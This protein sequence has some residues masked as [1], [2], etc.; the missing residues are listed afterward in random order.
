MSQRYKPLAKALIAVVVAIGLVLAARNAFSQWA[1]Q[2]RSA[3]DRVAQIDR[4]LQAATS[5]VQR[6]NLRSQRR[7]ALSAV[8]RLA[9]LNWSRIAAAGCCYALGLIPG[10]LVLCESTRVLGYRVSAGKAIAAQLV[11]HVGKYVPGKAMVVVIRAGRL[12][13]LGVPLV[14]GS[15]AVFLETLLMMAVGAAVAGCLVFWLPVPRWVAWVAL[16]GGIAATVPTLPPWIKWIVAKINAKSVASSLSAAP[17]QEREAVAAAMS[18]ATSPSTGQGWRF[19]VSAWCWQ[20]LAWLLIGASFALLVDSIPGRPTEMPAGTVFA[21]SV[22]S[23]ALAMVAGFASL[24]PGGAGVRELTLAMV[25]A[26]VI[27][28]SHALLA[29]ILARLLFIVVDLAAALAVAT[30]YREQ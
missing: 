14:V 15:I 6:E 18:P 9:N 25:L 24:L 12:S 5:E 26:P 30:L 20:G 11:G 29:A 2:Q 8:P 3:E 23:I 7:T 16:A 13:S 21:A 1:D 27:G 17:E 10:G 19:F 28:S 22:A 4:E